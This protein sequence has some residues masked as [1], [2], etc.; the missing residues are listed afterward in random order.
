MY[1]QMYTRKNKANKTHFFKFLSVFN[2]K[3]I[4]YIYIYSSIIKYV[5]HKRK[6][7]FK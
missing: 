2:Q 7:K 3:F 5:R 1:K 4:N 6:Q